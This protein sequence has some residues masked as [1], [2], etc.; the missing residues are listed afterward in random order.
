V[1]EEDARV[2]RQLVTSFLG[3][4]SAPSQLLTR[5]VLDN[6]QA[7]AVHLSVQA[8]LADVFLRFVC[9][10]PT[11]RHAPELSCD[12]GKVMAAPVLPRSV[13]RLTHPL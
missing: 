3:I 5:S 7:V 11:H 13:Q 2:R 9:A 12:S 4:T 8:T 1:A 10:S 6:E